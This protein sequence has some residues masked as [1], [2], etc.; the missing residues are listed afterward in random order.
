MESEQGIRISVL[1]TI[2]NALSLLSFNRQKIKMSSPGISIN[3]QRANIH[4]EDMKYLGSK[5]NAT[6]KYSKFIIGR[7]ETTVN[8]II[9]K[10]KNIYN[11]VDGLAQFKAD[12]IRTLIKSTLH[13]KAKNSYLKSEEDFKINGKKI[14]LG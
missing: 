7:L 9:S 14:H 3:T 12:R 4:A 5:F 1:N 2:G 10:A 13:V 8:D 6:I 11:T